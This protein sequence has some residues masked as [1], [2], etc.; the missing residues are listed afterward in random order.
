MKRF[1]TVVNGYKSLTIVE[2]LSILDV[3]E[4]PGNASGDQLWC[5]EVF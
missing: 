5:P 2:K 3:Y 4:G 1:A